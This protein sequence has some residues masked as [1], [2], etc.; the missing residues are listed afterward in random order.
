MSEQ[1][2]VTI[3]KLWDFL[4]VPLQGDVTDALANR[5]R[6]QVLDC[7]AESGADGL[8]IDV[9]GVWMIDSHLCSVISTLASSARL[10]GTESIVCGMSAD[11]AL[12]LQTMGVELDR[13]QTALSVEEAFQ[14]LGIGRVGRTRRREPTKHKNGGRRMR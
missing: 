1:D 14:A 11:I 13:V 10:M 12:T 9:T 2:R 8:I 6:Q 4:L 3:I 7:I 5:L